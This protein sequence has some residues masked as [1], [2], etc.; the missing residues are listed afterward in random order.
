MKLA[1]LEQLCAEEGIDVHPG[2]FVVSS[3]QTGA[4]VNLWVVPLLS[5]HSPG[6]DTEPEID[7]RWMGMPVADEVCSD[8]F[9]CKWPPPLNQKDGSVSDHLDSMNDERLGEAPLAGDDREKLEALFESGARGPGDIVISFSHFL[10]RIEL[11]PEKRYLY[12]PCLNKFVGSLALGARVSRLRPDIHIFG[13]THFG[14]DQD[15]DGVR[16]LSPPV[17]YPRERSVRISTIAIGDFPEEQTS[18][19]VLVWSASEG[20]PG[21]YPAGWSGFYQQ[22][23]REPHQ[24]LVLPDYVA[25]RYRWDEKRH[26][27]KAAVTGWQGKT[28]AWR[29]GPEWSQASRLQALD[30]H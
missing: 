20:F 6:F 19:P 16:Y 23:P 14:W 27:P 22:Y 2:R 10:P 4:D 25:D 9:Q 28:P 18:E 1:A 30:H 21:K 12:F 3:G 29:F 13:H 24:T 15:L 7:A 26:G 8:Y 5:W 17:G 11:T